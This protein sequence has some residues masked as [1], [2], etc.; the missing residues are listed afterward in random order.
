MI[1]IIV[2][3]FNQEEHTIK[4]LESIRAYT[5]NYRLIWVDNGS[6]L[7]SRCIVMP[8]FLKHKN[9]L[10][11]WSQ[12]NLGFVGGI[13]TALDSLI[14][15]YKTESEYIVLQNND[16]IVT[17]NW[18]S[19]MIDVFKKGD[20]KIAAVGPVSSVEGSVHCWKRLCE[21]IGFKCDPK[22]EMWDSTTRANYLRTNLKGIHCEAIENL[23]PPE[24]KMVAFF[25][26]VIKKSIIKEIG[27][28]DDSFGIGLC[29]DRDYCQRLYNAGYSCSIALDSYVEHNH[30][31]TFKAAFKKFQVSEIYENNLKRFKE[32]HKL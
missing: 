8:Y 27:F 13:N 14:N 21:N 30:S 16:T 6:S 23:K 15:V 5:E 19:A 9:R 22:F 20:S 3:T 7:M 31:T 25:A 17:H 26:A 18:L 24:V 11:I 32:K 28:L 12:K 29:D 4:C 2:L 10:N 1:D